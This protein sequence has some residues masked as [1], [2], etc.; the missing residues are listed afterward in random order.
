[1]EIIEEVKIAMKEGTDI[2][3]EYREGPRLIIR[4]EAEESQHSF[5]KC[6]R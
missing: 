4:E 2:R 5:K 6:D 1:L 3:G